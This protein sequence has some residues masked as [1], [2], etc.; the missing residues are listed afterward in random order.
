MN[1]KLKKS[2]SI[3]IRVLLACVGIGSSIYGVVWTAQP[4]LDAG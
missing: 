1:Q 2:L 4:A 3:G